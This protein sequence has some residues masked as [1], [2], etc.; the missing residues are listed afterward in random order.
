[1]ITARRVFGCL[2]AAALVAI[3][4]VA[5]AQDYPSRDKTIRIYLPVSPGASAD[6]YAR[7]IAAG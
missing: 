6:I 7:I 3:S 1:M 4:S 2:I 5:V